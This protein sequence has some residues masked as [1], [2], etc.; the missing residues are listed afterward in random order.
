MKKNLTIIAIALLVLAMAIP[1]SAASL[2]LS[3][4]LSA[5]FKYMH[6]DGEPGYDTWE[7]SYLESAGELNLEL[8]FKE[9]EGI[10]A[11]LPLTATLTA[12]P[13]VTVGSWYFEYN[14]APWAFWASKNDEDNEKQ[15]E[16]LGD[17]LGLVAAL[18]SSEEDPVAFAVNAKGDIAGVGLNLYAVDYFG[19]AAWLGRATYGLPLDFQLGLVGAYTDMA[20]GH[21]VFGADVTGKVPGID[22]DLTLA[23][24]GNWWK[25]GTW[26]FVAPPE[27]DNDNY[28]FMAKLENIKFDPISAW[29]KYT[30][31]GPTFGSIY[32]TNDE[33]I[34][35]DYANSAAAEIE[36][37]AELP[38]GIPTT[39]TLGDTLWMDYPATPKWNETTGKVEVSPLEN[40]KVTVSGAY[41]ADLNDEDEPGVDPDTFVDVPFGGYE[42]H[43]EVEYKAFGLILTPYADYK[44][45]SYAEDVDHDGKRVDT[46]VGAKVSGDPLPGLNINVEGSYQIEDPIAKA[47]AWALYATEL[48]PGF[49]K[50]AKSQLAGVAEL[51]KE[52]DGDAAT[53]FYGYAGS[54]VDITDNLTGKVG[55][56]TKDSNGTLAAHAALTYTA[57]DSI[58]T[59]LAYTYRNEGLE[60]PEGSWEPFADEGKNFLKAS[61][62]GTVGKS[63]ITLAYGAS[64]L[65]AADTSGFHKD[66]AWAWL[67]NYP[68]APMDWQLLTLSVKVPF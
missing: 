26:K 11:Y 60:H 35:D 27:A 57:S 16:S 7:P 64:G 42:A 41:K 44:A 65:K 34:L 20:P 49:V 47:K 37:S 3:G 12:T 15:F 18:P 58:S 4:D 19:W 5:T 48:N 17:P 63:T 14:T 50:S 9:G 25:E 51:T 45:D 33:D 62:T 39:L 24:A 32:A 59:S 36:V 67:R 23:A 10:V 56:L 28:A 46:I 31:V 52:G 30:A 40:L 55:I 61:V 2:S 13:N 38:V 1:A 21:L 22:A 29:V 54:D 53:D 68:T 8:T 43:G 6:R 66:K